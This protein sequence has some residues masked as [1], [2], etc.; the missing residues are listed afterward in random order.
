MIT[1]F[2]TILL[3]GTVM[4]LLSIPLYLQKIGPNGLYGFRV[5]KTLENPEL[6]YPVNKY[7]SV[8][9]MLAGGV[10]I[11]AAIGLLFVPGLGVDTYSLTCAAILTVV[12]TIMMVM[13]TRYMNTL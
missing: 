11:I 10:M 4:I 8:W 7:A 3:G 13:T 2:F 6:W 12:L 9:L 1:I 5:K